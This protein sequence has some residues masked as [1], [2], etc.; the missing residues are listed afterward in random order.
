M[1]DLTDIKDDGTLECL[2]LP[3]DAGRKRFSC[4]PEQQR[5][6]VGKTFWVLDYFADVRSRYSDDRYLF[7]LKFDL[8][9]SESDARKVWTGSADIKYVLD[10]LRELGKFPRRVTLKSGEGGRLYFE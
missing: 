4:P 1:Q 10:K 7:K 6:L 9:D 2:H 3:A 8:E 5:N